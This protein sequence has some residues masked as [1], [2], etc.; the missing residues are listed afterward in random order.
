MVMKYLRRLVISSLQYQ[1]TLQ[2]IVTPDNPG[3]PDESINP[4][5]PDGPKWPE[6]TGKDSLEKT[7][8]QTIKYIG[9]GSD[10]PKEITDHTTFTR[11]YVV[12][13][14]TGKILNPNESW[15]P[16]EH[17]F[18]SYK[19]PV[20]KGYVA[21][22]KEAGGFESTP[23]DPNKT[24]TVTYKKIGK[25]IP[26]DKD[27]NPIPG[28]ATPEYKNDPNDPTKVLPNE[29]IPT[30][31]GWKPT[32]SNVTPQD[33]TKDTPV[34]YTKNETPVVPPDSPNPIPE[35]TP[36]PQPEPKKPETPKTPEP[37]VPEPDEPEPDEP[38]E[39]DVPTPRRHHKNKKHTLAPKPANNWSNNYAPH[40]QNGYYN[41]FGS[42]GQGTPGPNGETIMPN[43]EVLD[44][45]GN[46][47]GYIDANGKI[48]YTL[49]QTG[50]NQSEGVAAAALGGAVVAIGLVSLVGVKRRHTN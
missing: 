25:I 31:D 2:L 24:Y 21:N 14:V 1:N 49:P 37:D 12:D 41:N 9:A 11:H 7:G 47:V 39:P 43:G 40:G 33:P 23:T 29:P 26:V 5:D 34:I 38:D 10:T 42:H 8:T 17:T 44:R 32:A 27:G 16:A 13:K 15:T 4:N 30:V 6:N 48:H 3:K 46:V 20:V 19:T 36:T 50:E 18:K 35:P 28:A 45:N 22:V